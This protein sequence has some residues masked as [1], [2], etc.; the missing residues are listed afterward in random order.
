MQDFRDA[1]QCEG[2]AMLTSV[3]REVCESPNLFYEHVQVQENFSEDNSL[4]FCDAARSLFLDWGLQPEAIERLFFCGVRSELHLRCMHHHH[5]DSVFARDELIGDKIL[6]TSRLQEW[7]LGQNGIPL[8]CCS[9][10]SQC[11]TTGAVSPERTFPPASP[12]AFLPPEDPLTIDSSHFN[13]HRIL[14]RT[15][16]GQQILSNYAKNGYL[17]SKEQSYLAHIIIDFHMSSKKRMS[18]SIF[19][20]YAAEIVKLFPT[21][22]MET[23]Y[24]PRHVS[25]KKNSAGKLYDRYRNMSYKTKYYKNL[26]LPRRESTNGTQTSPPA[27]QI[28]NFREERQLPRRCSEEEEKSKVWLKKIKS[29]ILGE[30]IFIEWRKTARL[31]RS[32]IGER[33]GDDISDILSEWPRYRDAN[34]HQLIE[35]DFD[36]QHP[37]K[38]FDLINNFHKLHIV[39]K[40]IF[41][42]EARDKLNHKYFEDYFASEIAFDSKDFLLTVLL[43]CL[44]PPARNASGKKPSISEAQED[45]V[46]CLDTP[47]KLEERITLIQNQPFAIHPRIFVIGPNCKAI[48][49]FYVFYSGILY[50]LPTFVKCIDLAIKIC[51]VFSIDFSQTSKLVW[52]FLYNLFFK[53]DD[54]YV[55]PKVLNLI[56]KVK[57]GMR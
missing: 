45:F 13:L 36:F 27:L 16:K 54:K 26:R 10:G 49:H 53:L 38:K 33:T 22:T 9:M 11:S 4:D 7:R 28:N 24:M 34:G 25:A 48:N 43:H 1:S 47:A 15:A 39:M 44:I 30:T 31:R 20:N 5:I 46:M 17:T 6:F 2:M 41:I 56:N 55:P 12:A 57:N 23:Y 19:E 29:D 3:K 21:E 37:G 32:E 50:K 52:S 18:Q 51:A 42:Q 40:P 14:R 8:G 35:I